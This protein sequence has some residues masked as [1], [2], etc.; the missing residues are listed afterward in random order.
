MITTRA[1]VERNAKTLRMIDLRTATKSRAAFSCTEWTRSRSARRCEMIAA[2][3][4]ADHMDMNFGCPV[5]RVTRKGGGAALPY[6][7]RLFGQIVEAAV[8]AA[9]PA[10]IPVTVK[11]RIG[12]D[13]EHHTYLEAGRIAAG[14]RRGLGRPARTHRRAALQRRGRLDRDQGLEGRSWTSRSWATATSGRP[15]TRC[16]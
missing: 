11:M 1:L 16:A 4:L 10:G 2:E 7:R 8:Q 9:A 15:T 14:R 3:D 12:I 6:K 13:E 5:P